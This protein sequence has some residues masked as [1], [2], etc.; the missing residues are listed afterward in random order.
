V[1]WSS[2]DDL[3]GAR[4]AVLRAYEEADFRPAEF[5]EREGI[6]ADLALSVEADPAESGEVPAEAAGATSRAAPG[7]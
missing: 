5:F 1:R 6:E 3:A 7:A 2:E 4:A